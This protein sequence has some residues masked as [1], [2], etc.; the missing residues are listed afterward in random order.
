[1][2]CARK[3]NIR[4]P[5]QKPNNEAI[6]IIARPLIKSITISIKRGNDPITD[7]TMIIHNI[8]FIR[9]T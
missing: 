3:L 1:M 6:A 9:L 7:K 4:T 8:I 5:K 2:G